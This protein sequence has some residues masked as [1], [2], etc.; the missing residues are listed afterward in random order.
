MTPYP[1]YIQQISFDG[2]SYTMGT[3]IDTYRNYDFA[4]KEFG[5]MIMPEPKPLV[6][7][8][9]PGEDGLEVYVPSTLR[10]KEF[11]IDAEFILL[12]DESVVDDYDEDEDATSEALV[13]RN[14]FV[15]F[16]YGRRFDGTNARLAIYDKHSE[17]GYKDVVVKKVTPDTSE[18]QYR[19][20]VAIYVLKVTFTVYDPVTSV[21]PVYNSSGVATGL[22]W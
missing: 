9:W 2:E 20:N 21:H 4:C 11:D 10:M 17:L 15:Q 22:T 7:R 13:L 18:R 1:F 14:S 5:E 6:T 16:L 3:F 19:G 12:G 8:D